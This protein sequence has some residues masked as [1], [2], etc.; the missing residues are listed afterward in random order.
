MSKRRSPVLRPTPAWCR[1]QR[2]RR[3]AACDAARRFDLAYIARRSVAA[4]NPAAPMVRDL[5]AAV[6]AAARPYVHLGATSQDVI[7]TAISLMSHR[8]L[9]VVLADLSTV[10]DACA[11]LTEEHATTV[12]TA[13]TLLQPAVPTTFGLKAAGWLVA[14]DEARA[15]LSH[16]RAHRLAIQLGGAGGT[17]APLEQHG[18]ESPTAL[19]AGSDLRNRSCPGTRIGRGARSRGRPGDDGRRARQDCPRRHP[20]RSGGGGRGHRE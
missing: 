13:R 7:D 12:M 9:S 3:S 4:G 11:A 15:L 6:S 16:V 20:A 17:L 19:P 1:T 8:A 14:L 10:A 18:I 2:L 5:T